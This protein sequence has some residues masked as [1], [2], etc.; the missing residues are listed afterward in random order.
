[1]INESAGPR[2]RVRPEP[3]RVREC[4]VLH[5]LA[6]LGGAAALA[7]AGVLAC[8]AGVAGL[9]AA[10]ALAG[11]LARA[12]VGLALLLLVGEDAGG[13]GA[14]LGR[15]GRGGELGGQAAGEKARDGGADEQCLA[16]G[17]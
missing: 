16:V 4:L 5:R 2:P 1:M 6:V 10:L 13:G 17:L 8:A 11:I 9:A 15:D 14:A 12:V 7:F 3:R